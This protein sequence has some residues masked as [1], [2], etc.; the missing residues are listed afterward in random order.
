ML[1]LSTKLKT[2]PFLLDEE[3]LELTEFTVNDVLRLINLQKPLLETG[4]SGVELMNEL[5]ISRVICSVK[6]FDTGEYFWNGTIDEFKDH[7]YPKNMLEELVNRTDE[8]NPIN[9]DKL[10]AKKKSS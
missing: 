9:L 2:I 7:N 8:I 1:K 6:R 3:K 10:G 4:L 5:S